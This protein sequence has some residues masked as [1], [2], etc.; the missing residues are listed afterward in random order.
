MFHLGVFGLIQLITD[1]FMLADC[2]A[3]DLVVSAAV[4]APWLV[5]GLIAN[6]LLIKYFLDNGLCFL[7]AFKAAHA[8]CRL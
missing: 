7:T 2:V 4:V 5:T 6:T 8:T 1:S 3:N